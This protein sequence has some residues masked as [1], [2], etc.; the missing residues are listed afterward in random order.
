ML[1]WLIVAW[2][3]G[4]SAASAQ[5]PRILTSF[6]AEMTDAY[7]ELW[8]AHAP[9]SAL[10]ILNKNTISAIE[11]IQRGNPRGFDLFWASSPEAFVILERAGAFAAPGTCGPDGPRAV[12]GFAVSS[13]GW[14]RRR[15]STLFMPGDWNDLLL[16]V[17][18]DQIAMARPARSGTTHVLVEQM[19]QVRG[20]DEGWAYLL[21]LSGN[22]ST[23]TARSFGVP[24][25]LVSHRF[26]I[27]LTLDF[28]ALSR[29]EVLQF[30]YGRPMMTVTAQIGLLKHGTRTQDACD[31]VR[32]LLSPRGQQTL[33]A[34]KVSRVPLDPAVREAAADRLPS[35]MLAALRLPW[36]AYDAELSADRYWSVNAL[37]DVMIADALE[38]RRDLWQRFR[39]LRGHAPN[40]DLRRVATL[41][42]T[43][44]VSEAEAAAAAR[45]PQPGLRLA[46]LVGLAPI[47]RAVIDT[48]RAQGDDLLRQAAAELGRLEERYAP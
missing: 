44:P 18:R 5:E 31:F 43:V 9:K 45:H 24:D 40:A 7:Q 16:P 27:G 47:E 14:A 29:G 46:P 25:G 20:W 41:L 39:R 42:T 12:E 28:L 13:V 4:V 36:L 3:F 48:W 30:T 33:L 10:R 37:F 11:E 17:Y 34:P 26:G 6:P 21:G 35:D 32:L 22:L 8:Q 19:L 23:L 1:R 38:Q 2:F 15:D